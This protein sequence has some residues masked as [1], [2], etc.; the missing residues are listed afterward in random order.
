MDNFQRLDIVNLINNSPISK[1]SNEFQTN[2]LHKIQETFTDD[3]QQL[4][5]ASFYTYLNYNSKTDFVIDLDKVWKW[6]GF[7]RKDHAKTLLLKHFT[8]DIDFIVSKAASAIAEAGSNDS[9]DD[10]NKQFEESVP[11]QSREN[12]GGRPKEQILMNINC[13]KKFC[14]KSGTNK[15]MSI[16]AHSK[17]LVRLKNKAEEWRTNVVIVDEK[18][19][20]KTCSVCGHVK[21][22]QFT[23]KV[24][25]CEKCLITIDRDRNGAINILKKL[26]L[27]KGKSGA[28]RA[29]GTDTLVKSSSH[30]IVSVCQ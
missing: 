27:P 29:N 14:L 2:L 11:P 19:T 20:S 12:L 25:N 3:Q 13:F 18:Y 6:I 15:A 4:F 1:L 16:L 7:S 23:S 17:F 28:D 24:Y 30:R 10:E 21:T 26:F 9:N 8:K 5:V 22:K